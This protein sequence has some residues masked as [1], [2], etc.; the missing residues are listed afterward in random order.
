MLSTFFFFKYNA[1]SSWIAYRKGL[2]RSQITNAFSS[3]NRC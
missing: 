1:A 3:A 2:L